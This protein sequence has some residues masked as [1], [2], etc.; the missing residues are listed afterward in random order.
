MATAIATAATLIGKTIAI[1]KAV[2]A[3]QELFQAV[4]PLTPQ[5]AN[6]IRRLQKNLILR[7]N[8]I[9]ESVSVIDDDKASYSS[10]T[11][12]AGALVHSVV[13][14]VE[15]QCLELASSEQM[16]TGPEMLIEQLKG[17]TE[18]VEKVVPYFVLG[19]QVRGIRSDL[20]WLGFL[21]RRMAAAT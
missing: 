4:K 17:I 13:Q 3:I 7:L 16:D 20:I 11:K 12:A 6:E 14:D 9:S 18:M 5:S 19:M 21:Q 15:K 2:S 10:A 1:N 8:C